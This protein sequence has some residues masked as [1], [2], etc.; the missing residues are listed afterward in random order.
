MR[1]TYRYATAVNIVATAA[2]AADSAPA[3]PRMSRAKKPLEPNVCSLSRMI[4][5]LNRSIS[6]IRM[7]AAFFS[8]KPKKP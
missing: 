5:P 3:F 2:L 6:Y 1:Q 4:S 7:S 8:S